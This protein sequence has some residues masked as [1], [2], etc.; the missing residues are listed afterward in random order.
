MIND[1]QDL[2]EAYQYFRKKYKEKWKKKTEEM[3]WIEKIEKIKPTWNEKSN[4]DSL[5]YH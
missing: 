5:H 3:R 4:I 1:I 2:S